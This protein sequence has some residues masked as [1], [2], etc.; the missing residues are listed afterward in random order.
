MGVFENTKISG[1]VAALA[2]GVSYALGGIDQALITLAFFIGMDFILGVVH[3]GMDRKLS[4]DELLK[5]VIKKVGFF[6]L[7]AVV[8]QIERLANGEAGPLRDLVIF[9]L[10]SNEGL[11][12][13]GHLEAFGVPMPEKIKDVLKSLQKA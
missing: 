8:V 2:G 6:F 5:G 11:S 13:L 7:V 4:T 9:F 1:G 3:A 12:I 10:V